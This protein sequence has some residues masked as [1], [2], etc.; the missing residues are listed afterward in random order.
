MNANRILIIEDDLTLSAQ[1]AE[2]L[3]GKGF[4]IQQCQDGELG[5]VAALEQH[6]DLILLGVLQPGMS[7]FSILEQLR[8]VKQT[9][10]MMV[11]AQGAEQERIQGYNSGADDCLSKPFNFT[12]LLVRIEV[13]L[14]RFFGYNT[15][16]V[17][18]NSLK[19]DQ[20]QLNR[21]TQQAEFAGIRLSF[22]PVQFKLLW[23]LLQNKQQVLS[24]P[25]L[26][27]TV[28]GRPFSRCDRSLDMHMSR[29]RKK[30]EEA[31][32]QPDRLVTVHGK[33][34]CFS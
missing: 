32:M 22:T 15:T 23:V 8:K 7:G 6:F 4:K 24:K 9:P 29:V 2:F 34:Y 10:V 19:V 20:I 31:G 26:Y 3:Q 14:R 1:V 16:S 11:T 33:G 25:L 5:L 30:L 12:E 27:Q 17:P 13:L 18:G 21:S 28:L